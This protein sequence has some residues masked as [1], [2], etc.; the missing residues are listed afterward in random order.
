MVPWLLCDLSFKW[1]SQFNFGLKHYG[2]QLA[3]TG[4]RQPLAA[5][6]PP[7]GLSQPSDTVGRCLTVSVTRAILDVC[8]GIII[9]KLII[10]CYFCQ[11]IPTIRRT[12]LDVCLG[13][14]II[15]LII[16]CYFCQIIPL[17]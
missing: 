17:D 15:K 5:R 10:F 4:S 11:I 16:F 2:W 8:L 13:I 14:I 6:G 7:S 12:I 9:I 1:L 3:A